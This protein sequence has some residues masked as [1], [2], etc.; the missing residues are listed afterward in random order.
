ME[1]KI[2]HLSSG[3]ARIRADFRLTPDV[4]AYF[5]KQAKKIQNINKIEFYQDEYTFAVIYRYRE[6][7][8]LL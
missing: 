1:F 6:N 5:K 2:L 3:R 7:Q 8:G 4:K